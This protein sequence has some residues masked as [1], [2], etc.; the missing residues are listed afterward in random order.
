L[1]TTNSSFIETRFAILGNDGIN[2]TPI[3]CITEHR[4]GEDTGCGKLSSDVVDPSGWDVTA[5][6]C[7]GSFNNGPDF[8][9]ISGMD[10]IIVSYHRDGIVIPTNGLMLGA[11]RSSE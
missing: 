11:I 8:R 1:Y 6:R 9:E 7:C 4:G 5:L 3:N 2:I 10:L